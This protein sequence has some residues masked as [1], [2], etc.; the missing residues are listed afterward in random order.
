M[1]VLLCE[2]NTLVHGKLRTAGVMT[3]QDAA[4][5]AGTFREALKMADLRP[6]VI[7]PAA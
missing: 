5:Y 7:S 2:A 6:Q 3:E 1:R 4:A